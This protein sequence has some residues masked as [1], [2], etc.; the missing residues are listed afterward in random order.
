ML[1]R[2]QCGPVISTFSI[3]TDIAFSGISW[4]YTQ[5]SLYPII[6]PL[7]L[8]RYW[9][10]I[11]PKSMSPPIQY[12]ASIIC[13]MADILTPFLTPFAV[14]FFFNINQQPLR[15]CISVYS[16]QITVSIIELFFS[17]LF[18]DIFFFIPFA[19]FPLAF[20]MDMVVY[21]RLL[22]VGINTR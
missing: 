13:D 4:A 12:V 22:R 8:C 14:F 18:S 21:P 20:Q 1:S 5:Y 9:S 3:Q 15:S 7:T 19:F 16:F 11:L 10:N 17:V 2:F 6:L